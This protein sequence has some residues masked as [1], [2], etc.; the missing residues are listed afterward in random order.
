MGRFAEQAERE[1][2]RQGRQVI[3]AQFDGEDGK[4]KA[5]EGEGRQG[6][7]GEERV[8]PGGF[9]MAPQIERGQTGGAYQ[10]G[11]D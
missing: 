6:Y 11:G 2:Q 1:G 7:I 10:E 4:I 3:E 9:R 8:F 5:V